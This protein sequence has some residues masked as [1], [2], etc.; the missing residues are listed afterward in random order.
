MKNMRLD[1]D[2]IRTDFDAVLFDM[3]GT[4]VD[5][6]WIWNQVDIDFLALYG[7]APPKNLKEEIEGMSYHETAEYFKATFH[8]TESVE[9]IISIWNNMAHE[10]YEN[11]VSAKEGLEAFIT[12]LKKNGKRTAICTSNSLFLTEAVLKRYPFLKQIDII[13]TSDLVKKGKPNPDVYLKAAE[14]LNVKPSK[15]LVFEDLPNGILAGRNAGMTTCTLDDPFSQ[16]AIEKKIELA[17]Y[18]IHNYRDIIEN[19]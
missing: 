15:C 6:M 3:D 9:E 17:D 14:L 2:K 19:L 13:I 12:F 18:Y 7:L 1:L 8:L 10:K 11:E 4:L 5:S 16:H